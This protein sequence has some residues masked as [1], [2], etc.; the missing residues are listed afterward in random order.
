MGE[1]LLYCLLQVAKF[2]LCAADLA[3]DLL[4]GCT[5]AGG[6]R[7]EREEAAADFERSAQVVSVL[8]RARPIELI[9]Y[10]LDNFLWVHQE[11]VDPRVAVLGAAHVTLFTV[12]RDRAAF[13]VSDPGVDV[14]DTRVHPWVSFSQYRVA[15]KLIIIPL[16]SLRVLAEGLGDPTVDVSLVHMTTRKQFHLKPHVPYWRPAMVE[17]IGTFCQKSEPS[18]EL[19]S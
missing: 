4:F 13:C 19:S 10:G 1:V 16:G 7:R 14:Y 5:L 8:L 6:T 15:E 11:Y 3:A 18:Q 12:E 2:L 9:P 17:E